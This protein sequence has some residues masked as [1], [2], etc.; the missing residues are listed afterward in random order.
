MCSDSPRKDAKLAEL[1]E[2]LRE[3]TA[4]R[5]ELLSVFNGLTIGVIVADVENRT[6]VAVNP[7]ALAM[8][9]YS[10]QEMLGV[11]ISDLHP[12]DSH[13]KMHATFAALLRDP[14]TMAPDFPCYRKDRS[15]FYAD[16]GASIA[17]YHGRPCA[18]GFFIDVTQRLQVQNALVAERDRLE[19]V[20]RSA[21]VGIAIISPDYRT[22][23][24]NTVIR[25][26]FGETVGKTCYSTY[27]QQKQI[28]S[29]CGARRI[30]ENGE[31]RVETEAVGF[32]AEGNRIWSQIIATAIRDDSGRTVAA[33]EVVVPITERKLAEEKLSEYTRQLETSRN[34]LSEQAQQLRAAKE[35]AEEA[36][37]VKSEFLAS[38]SHEIRTPMNGILGMANL[39]SDTDLNV[40]QRECLSIIKDS[41]HALLTVINDILDFSKV[42]AGKVNIERRPFSLLKLVERIMRLTGVRAT[43]KRLNIS[44]RIIRRLPS[45]FSGDEVRI[46][47]IL[48][49]LLSNAVKFTPECGQVELVVDYKSQPEA[50]N[51]CG[52]ALFTVNDSGIGVPPEKASSIFE[53]FVQAD[54]RTSRKFGGTGL[55][56]SISRKLAELMGGK[57]WYEPRNGGGSSFHLEL[58]MEEIADTDQSAQSSDNGTDIPFRSRLYQGGKILVVD[59]NLVNQRLMNALLSRRGYEVLVAEDGS[60]ALDIFAAHAGQGAHIALVFMD[61]EMPVMNGFE[62]TAQIRRLD[63]E[64]GTHTL[65]VALTAYAMTGDRE[66]CLNAGMDDY[67]SKPIALEELDRVLSRWA[68]AGPVVVHSSFNPLD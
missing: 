66:K 42:E 54:F 22:I 26:C 10:E 4:S 68:S 60:K 31:E 65:I 34:Q 62:A 17:Q 67:I 25:R 29:F 23:W 59:D 9:G 56:L 12:A 2:Q 5:D 24:A 57:I 37:R 41:A 35:E 51:S 39:L 11:P 30:F 21:G 27:N 38:V 32:D 8:F 20:T 49:N 47:Q 45:K 1:Q 28:C 13:E 19:T 33:L 6:I 52:R 7:A 16:I 55:G 58:P 61:C 36:S 46:G 18:I 44:S 64:R 48:L 63:Q 53:A 15:L 14:K 40:E 50:E 3:V 43:S